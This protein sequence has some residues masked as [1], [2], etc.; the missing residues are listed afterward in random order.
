MLRVHKQT[1]KL[2]LIKLKSEENAETYIVYA[3]L[4]GAVHSLCV[5]CVV[6]LGA[7]GMK[8]LVGFLMVCLL[9]KYVCADAGFFQLSVILHGGGGDIHVNSSD[10]AVL[11]LYGV[12]G[13]DALQ[14]VFYGIVDRVLSRLNG[15]SLVT[16]ILESYYLRLDL[17]LSQL[18]SGNMLVLAVIWAVYASVYAIV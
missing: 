1:C 4:H 2:V 9:E 17:L 10:G 5:V 18:L 13:V 11:V 3:A 6:V 15:K 14:D 8:L 16:H 7:C 12:D